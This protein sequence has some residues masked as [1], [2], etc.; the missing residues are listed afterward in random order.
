MSYLENI[1]TTVESAGFS[2]KSIKEPRLQ[3]FFIP[4]GLVS[5]SLKNIVRGGSIHPLTVP[6]PGATESINTTLGGSIDDELFGCFS[7]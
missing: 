2:L 1:S 7:G 5:T 3:G 6:V 4:I